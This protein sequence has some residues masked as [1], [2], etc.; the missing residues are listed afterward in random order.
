MLIDGARFE[1]FGDL[2]AIKE[3]IARLETELAAGK[4]KC[5]LEDAGASRSQAARIERRASF[6]W[7][8]DVP[9]EHQ[10]LILGA[11]EKLSG[12]SK[13]RESIYAEAA[14]AARVSSPKQTREFTNKLVREENARLA[15]DPHEAYR[16]RRF[17]VRAQDEH[18]GCSFYG[19]APASTAALLKA[20]LDRSFKADVLQE[21]QQDLR[22]IP[23]RN[24]D[25]FDQ[26][27]RWA[28]SDR[29][30]AT[31]HASLVVSV[32][33][34]DEFDWRAKFA[35]NVGIDLSL[36]DLDHLADD[37]ITDYIVVHDHN[38]AVKS[39]VTGERCA[40]FFQ[41]VA[42]VARDLVCQY[43]GCDEP[44]S[45]CDAHHVMPWNRGGRTTIGNLALMCRAHHRRND[46]SFVEQHL[47]MTLGRPLWVDLRGQKCR[48]TSPAARK[49]GASRVSKPEK[50]P[51]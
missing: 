18:G 11:L 37:K 29:I 41:R 5:E 33:E 19:Y 31:G 4:E 46:D 28:S 25:A 50:P 17:A 38:G 27:L 36:F 44:A 51:G 40:N 32:S 39:L 21:Q 8:E 43:P 42:L 30:T 47:E 34:T 7:F 3:T 1:S 15:K 2:M 9:V 35:T 24:M 49:S 22:T 14:E 26:V 48:N 12:A 13:M 23:Q 10:D 16:Q 20:L 6:P 45:R